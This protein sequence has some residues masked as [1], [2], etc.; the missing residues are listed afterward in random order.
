VGIAKVVIME[1]EEAVEIE[2]EMEELVLI[3]F[4]EL[5]L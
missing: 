2:M 5:L 3:W 1:M 4:L